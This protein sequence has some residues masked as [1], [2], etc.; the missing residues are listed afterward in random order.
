MKSFFKFFWKETTVRISD[1]E[2]IELGGFIISLF[3]FLGIL[4]LLKLTEDNQYGCEW[5]GL[6][7]YSSEGVYYK[8]I[9]DL[10]KEI[11]VHESHFISL[12]K[13]RSKKLKELGI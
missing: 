3:I 10:G 12:D 6:M 4:G 11:E 13:W 1:N 7:V 8:L 9:N 2:V 5:N